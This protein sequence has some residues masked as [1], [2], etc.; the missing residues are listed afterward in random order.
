[1]SFPV[2][3]GTAY[4]VAVDG[5]SGAQGSLSLTYS[6]SPSAVTVFPSSTRI[7]R[8]SLRGGGV[9]DLWADDGSYFRVNSTTSG[10]RV[11]SW[12]A[13]FSGVP[14]DLHG[15]KVTYRGRDNRVS[16]SQTI[17][18]FNWR[19]NAWVQL[20]ARTIGF[21]EVLIANLVAP[22]TVRDYVSVSSGTG[23]VRVRV[24]SQNVAQPFV[25]RGELMKIVF[26]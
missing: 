6:V 25:S 16:A 13:E 7:L 26:T 21:D 9:G 19:T 12:Y 15:L 1:V 2:V 23:E 11:T 24:R 8:G 10:N 14:A 22:G 20:D 4:A 18:I 17:A 3:A 5:Y